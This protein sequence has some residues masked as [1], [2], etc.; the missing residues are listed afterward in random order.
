MLGKVYIY[1]LQYDE[2]VTKLK[3]V[4]DNAGKSLVSYNILRNSFHGE[5]EFNSESLFEVNY[6]PDPLNTSGTNVTMYNTGNRFEVYVSV[7]YLTDA[8]TEANNGFGNLFVHDLNIPRYGFDDTT[9]VNQKRADYLAKSKQV[10]IDKSV[11]P[12]LYVL[13]ISLFWIVFFMRASGEG[14]RRTVWNH[15]PM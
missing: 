10:R 2:A 8:G 15:I 12:R 1:N 5:N 9:T 3:D 11:D 13:C 14:S 6:T 4:I 7:S